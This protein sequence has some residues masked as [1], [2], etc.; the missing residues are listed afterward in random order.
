MRALLIGDTSSRTNWGCRATSLG[1]RNL[2][3]A[4]A[5][6]TGVIDLKTGADP[7]HTATPAQRVLR[8]VRPRPPFPDITPAN[9]T[10]V[11]KDLVRGRVAPQIADGLGDADV[12]IVNGEGSILKQKTMGRRALAVAR[13][14]AY[15]G[16]PV[17][18]VNHSADLA[19]PLM[20][21]IASQVYPV[22]DDVVV[23]ERPSLRE[24]E[25]VASATPPAL[26]ADAAF[27][28]QSSAP[29]RDIICLGGSAAFNRPDLDH[30]RLT[31]AFTEL[32]RRLGELGTV[33]VTVASHPDDQ[34]LVP[35]AERLDLEVWGLDTGTQEAVDLL[36]GATLY[37]GG[38]W[39]PGIFS[40]GG[41]TPIVMFTS[42]SENKSSGL[43]DIAGLEQATLSPFDVATDCD[44]IV[45]LAADRIEGGQELRDTIA[46]S[47]GPWS[48]TADRNVRILD[49][50][51]G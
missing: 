29:R 31:D 23:R 40:V 3:E 13:A 21:A 38:R 48:R 11:A 35:V 46:A 10:S 30:E 8:R 6:L 47:V 5:E 15:A 28:L 9:L 43:L 4:R 25:G 16:L 32:A 44:R 26:A 22:V 45:E 24:L 1:L 37:V 41:G 39:H 34:V 49:G 2:I 17:A 50:G 14:A 19:D 27:T 18:V 36:A 7:N 33:V 20:A 51:D 12:V 42:N